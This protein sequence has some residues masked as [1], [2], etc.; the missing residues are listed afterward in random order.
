MSARI[1]LQ[2]ARSA[3]FFCMRLDSRRT[4]VLIEQGPA[5]GR[6]IGQ[7]CS[8]YRFMQRCG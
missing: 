5:A 3:G 4:V 7:W 2:T 8:N 6:R 1:S